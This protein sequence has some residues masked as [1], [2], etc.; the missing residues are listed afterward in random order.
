MRFNSE[1]YNKLYP[2]K[3][4]KEFIESAVETFTP[5]IDEVDNVENNVD[6]VENNII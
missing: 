3:K 6:N 5:T 1:A 2:R 4:D